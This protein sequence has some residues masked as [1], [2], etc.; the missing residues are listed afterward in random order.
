MISGPGGGGGGGGGGGDG[1][2]GGDRGGGERAPER[3]RPLSPLRK[4]LPLPEG[5]E[6]RKSESLE[7]AS[8]A[9][10]SIVRPKGALLLPVANLDVF[11]CTSSA[12]GAGLGGALG[13]AG[14]A[15]VNGR[16][17]IFSDEGAVGAFSGGV[18]SGPLST[19]LKGP[20]D[21]DDSSS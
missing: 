8:L 10:K 18:F 13:L 19:F 21:L 12:L 17:L 1:A 14:I 20:P 11:M 6:S 3:L 16:K 5:L 9:V 15:I 2:R 4:S 7:R